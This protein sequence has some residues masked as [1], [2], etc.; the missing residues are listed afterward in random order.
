MTPNKPNSL[1]AAVAHGRII[2]ILADEHG[3]NTLDCRF[4]FCDRHR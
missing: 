4:A 3:K 2:L 1:N